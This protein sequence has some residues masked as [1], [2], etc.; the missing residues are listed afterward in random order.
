LMSGDSAHVF[1]HIYADF[2]S[3]RLCYPHSGWVQ[4]FLSKYGLRTKPDYVDAGRDEE[5][6]RK[7]RENQATAQNWKSVLAS[8]LPQR[9]YTELFAEKHAEEPVV[10]PN[11]CRGTGCFPPSSGEHQRNILSP[12]CEIAL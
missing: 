8:F 12:E 9:C 7:V 1:Q 5:V 6:Y 2:H 4:E 3:L 10:L 11:P